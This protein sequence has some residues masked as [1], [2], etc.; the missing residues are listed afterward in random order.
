MQP[1]TKKE[2]FEEGFVKYRCQ[3]CGGALIENL[4]EGVHKC[5]FCGARY[6]IEN[7]DGHRRYHQVILPCAKVLRAQQCVTHEHAMMADKEDVA[8]FAK[9]RLLHDLAESLIPYIVFN[10]EF[11]EFTMEHRFT[12]TL[13]VLGKDFK[14]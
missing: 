8:R 14:F 9:E 6:I 10:E 1:T 2:D 3:N 5:G 4:K 12:G 11:N 13:R 7:I